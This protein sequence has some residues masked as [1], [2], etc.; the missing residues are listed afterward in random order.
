[1]T[2]SEQYLADLVEELNADREA[3]I[4]KETELGI[5]VMTIW[6]VGAAYE[7]CHRHFTNKEDAETFLANKGNYCDY[8]DEI[9]VY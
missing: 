8:I 9:K 1:M 7:P 2:V 5:P 4:L 3:K 6:G